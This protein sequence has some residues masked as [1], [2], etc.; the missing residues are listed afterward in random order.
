MIKAPEYL[1][2]PE[3]FYQVIEP[4]PVKK[5]EWVVFNTRLCEE[6]A[7]NPSEL[8][9]H[10]PQFSGNQAFPEV[11]ALAM[12]YSGHQFGHFTMLGDGRAHL[13]GEL[14]SNDRLFEIHLKGSGRTQ[15]SRGGDGRA[16]LEPML[17]EY[18][19]SE[20]LHKLGIPSTR[21]LGV[22]KT[23]ETIQRET[24]LPGAIVVRIASSH[25]RVGT[26]EYAA[27]LN[28]PRHLQALLDFAIQRHDPDLKG[29][30]SAPLDFFKRVLK[31]QA[32]LVAQWM[33]IGFVHGVM[34][35]DNMTISGETID[36][37]PCAIMGAFDPKTVFSSI[38]RHGRYAFANQ[39][40]I[41]HWNLTRLAEA[42]LPL[43]SKDPKVAQHMASEALEEFPYLFE[44]TYHRMLA[45]KLGFSSFSDRLMP[46]FDQLFQWLYQNK[47]DWN[48]T[49]YQLSHSKIDELDQKSTPQFCQFLDLW[50]NGLLER[51]IDFTSAQTQMKQLNPGQLPRNHLVEKALHQ[52][53][54][55]NEKPFID[56]IEA[57]QSP[58]DSDKKWHNFREPN[59]EFDT[60]YQTFCG[61]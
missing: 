33:G 14:S 27:T 59:L 20:S 45:K 54:A 5:P 53:S 37:G 39:P 30:P 28:S 35:T 55:G 3:E 4:T 48:H 38:D 40:R 44:S 46:M 58:Y 34:N 42:L 12:A 8:M 1:H 17:R 51:D 56:L 43:F 10:L 26:F 32:Q 9:S 61:T 11:S 13:I 15:F 23:G 18:L 29:S 49:F 2:L 41:A 57:L 47:K 6:L 50:K 52:M 21:C 16:A 60:E 25:L 19:M 22:V 24:P 7:L 36:Y 31:R